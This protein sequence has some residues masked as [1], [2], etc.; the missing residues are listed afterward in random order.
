MGY[1]AWTIMD[2]GDGMLTQD[3][4]ANG[5][6]KLMGQ[7]RSSDLLE[8]IADMSSLR[9]EILGLPSKFERRVDR[10]AHRLRTKSEKSE[11]SSACAFEATKSEKSYVSSPSEKSN[12]SALVDLGDAYFL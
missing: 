12:A 3:Q 9:A 2:A 4:L 6:S 7:A 5:I 1:K 11:K 8:L 10:R